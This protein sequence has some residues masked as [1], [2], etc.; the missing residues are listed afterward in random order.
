MVLNLTQHDASPDQIEAGVLDLPEDEREAA[1]AWLTFEDCPLSA[2]VAERAADLAELAA[3]SGAWS[4]IGAPA[5]GRR[6]MLGGAP[7]LMA[8]LV[9]ALRALHLVPVFAFSRRESVDVAQADGSVRKIASF[10]HAGWVEA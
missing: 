6:V 10:R 4:A 5:D 7:W 8:P 2:D 3:M 9:A 1:I